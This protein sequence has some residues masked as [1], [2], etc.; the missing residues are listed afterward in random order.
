MPQCSR[1]GRAICARVPTAQIIELPGASLYLIRAVTDVAAGRSFFSPAVAR[2]ML[3]DYVRHLADKGILDRYDALS[4]REREVFQLIAEGHSNKEMADVLSISSATVET[5]R[6]PPR[7]HL[8][9]AGSAQHGRS[10]A[11]RRPARRHLLRT[12]R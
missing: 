4:E 5:H 12:R 10:R 7:P 11:L 6:A 2:I 1:D 3:D 8:P 9:E